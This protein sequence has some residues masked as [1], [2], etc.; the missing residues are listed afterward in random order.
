MKFHQVITL[1]CKGIKIW[2]GVGRGAIFFGGG[3]GRS[4]F[5][6]SW[7]EFLQMLAIA[8]KSVFNIMTFPNNL[9]LSCKF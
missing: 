6:A 8:D 9:V 4:K 7:G 5:S 2:W 1:F 3:G